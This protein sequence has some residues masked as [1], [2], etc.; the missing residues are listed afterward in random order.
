LN[1]SAPSDAQFSAIGQASGWLAARTCQNRW[2][3]SSDC[4]V[5]VRRLRITGLGDKPS[6]TASDLVVCLSCRSLPATSIDRRVI[7][8]YHRYDPDIWSTYA[9]ATATK[10]HRD[11]GRTSILPA[12]DPTVFA[13]RESRKSKLNPNPTPLIAALDVTGS[14]GRVA[15]AMRKGLGTLFEQVITRAVIPDPHVLAIA[16]GDFEVDCAP[17]QATQFEGEPVTIGKQIEDLWLEGGGGGNDFEGYLGPLYFAAMRTDC[18]AIRDGRKG[19]LFT[20]GDEEPQT[21][22]RKASVKRFFGDA[23]QRDLAA[24]ELIS[25]VSRGWEY[26]HRWLLKGPTCGPVGTASCGHGPT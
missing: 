5:Q 2:R 15:E 14:M 25:L 8:G 7:I 13:M 6:K 10:T 11:Y 18:D 21:V 26:F 9:R 23:I 19:F 24:E 20:A 1:P 16:I 22:L 12:F 17:I 4:R 3:T